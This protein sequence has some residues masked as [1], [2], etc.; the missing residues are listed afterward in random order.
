MEQD[1]KFQFVGLNYRKLNG[2]F[3][4]EFVLTAGIFGYFQKEKQTWR[5]N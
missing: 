2:K 3:I 5:M 1:D 4:I